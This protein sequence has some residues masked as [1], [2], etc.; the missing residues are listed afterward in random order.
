MPRLIILLCAC[1]LFGCKKDDDKDVD[2]SP[3]ITYHVLT[4]HPWYRSEY[5]EVRTNLNSGS[6]EYDSTIGINSCYSDKAMILKP[7]S[8]ASYDLSCVLTSPAPNTGTWHLAADSSFVVNIPVSRISYGTGAIIV[9]WGIPFGKLLEVNANRF[10][11]LSPQ[12]MYINGV[13][14]RYDRYFTFVK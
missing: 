3:Q 7:D 6:V 9:N 10:K 4:S 8:T 5:R 1:F 12:V 2:T 14:Y 13:P 11:A